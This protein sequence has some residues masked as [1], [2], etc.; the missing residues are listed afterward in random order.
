MSDNIVSV[1]VVT[2]GK[3]VWRGTVGFQV[4]FEG[5]E[6]TADG[7][8]LVDQQRLHCRQWLSVE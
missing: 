2:V 3:T 1:Y 5:I 7:S 4:F 8:T 6:W